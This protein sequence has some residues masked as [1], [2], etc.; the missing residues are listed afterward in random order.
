V[1]LPT[2]APLVGRPSLG[3]R[4][5]VR[6]HVRKFWTALYKEIKDISF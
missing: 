5:F 1:D 4:V 2:Q 3:S 6:G